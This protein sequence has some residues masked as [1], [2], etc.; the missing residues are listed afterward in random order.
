MGLIFAALGLWPALKVTVSLAVP[1]LTKIGQRA[2]AEEEHTNST[3]GTGLDRRRE[4]KNKDTKPS[5]QPAKKRAAKPSKSTF[6]NY[7]Q[8]M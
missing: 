6:I 2:D 5:S 1:T 8:C 4:R 3:A 7:K